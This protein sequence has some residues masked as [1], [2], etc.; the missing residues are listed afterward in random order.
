MKKLVFAILLFSLTAAFAGD[1]TIWVPPYGIEEAKSTLVRDFG[2]I[3]MKDA[4]TA[5]GLQFWVPDTD[6]VVL[7][8]SYAGSG[9]NDLNPTTVK[10]FTDWGKANGVPVM[11]CVYNSPGW[12]WDEVRATLTDENRPKFVKALVDTMDK[13]GLDGIDID[14]EGNDS[15]YGIETLLADSTAFFKFSRQLA[16][17]VHAREGK[18]LKIA[19]FAD[20]WNV[21]SVTWWRQLLKIYDGVESM[22][23]KSVAAPIHGNDTASRTYAK[24]IDSAL[25][26]GEDYARRLMIGFP[27]DTAIWRGIPFMENLDWMVEN[28]GLTDSTSVGICIWDAQLSDTAIWNHSTVWNKLAQISADVR[29]KKAVPFD[30][31]CTRTALPGRF[32]LR[33]RNSY[34]SGHQ[35]NNYASQGGEWQVGDKVV[36]KGHSCSEA[37][38][39]VAPEEGDSTYVRLAEKW[40]GRDYVKFEFEKVAWPAPEDSTGISAKNFALPGFRASATVYG[41]TGQALLTLPEAEWSSAE[42]LRDAIRGRLPS[43][44]YLVRFNGLPRAMKLP[45]GD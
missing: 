26:A 16:D 6:R 14:Y 19:V 15:Q 44:V 38:E 28:H 13:Y 36:I 12:N 5:L 10:W 11:L 32:N 41:I 34:L 3:K 2:G 24:L 37:M 33:Y 25:T 1:I 18:V 30:S 39:V 7:K 17:S 35:K 22:G 9:T 27:S 21:P 42:Q 43:G 8:P 23:Y 45:V 20:R 40:Y 31:S 29:A 4:I